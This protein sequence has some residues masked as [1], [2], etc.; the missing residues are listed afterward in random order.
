MKIDL[1]RALM[2]FRISTGCN[3]IREKLHVVENCAT[4]RIGVHPVNTLDQKLLFKAI[5]LQTGG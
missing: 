5:I 1:N 4:A 3:P 2:L